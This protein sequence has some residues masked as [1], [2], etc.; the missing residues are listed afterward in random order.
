MG[1]NATS[2]RHR[3]VFTIFLAV[4]SSLAGCGTAETGI[5]TVGPIPP[6]VATGTMTVTWTV[7]GAAS[8]DTCDSVGAR[9]LSLSVFDATGAQAVDARA[10]C[11]DFAIT[12]ELP[13]GRYSADV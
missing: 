11:A 6:G 13:E 2:I 5:V 8:A 1:T 7:L 4:L 12:I 9:D 3:W 10:D